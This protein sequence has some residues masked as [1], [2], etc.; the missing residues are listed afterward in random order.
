MGNIDK[1]AVA[2]NEYSGGASGKQDLKGIGT[3]N[4]TREVIKKIVA[5]GDA[6]VEAILKSV[7]TKTIFE[8]VNNLKE[9]YS[10]DG[11][12]PL[13]DDNGVN[14]KSSGDVSN[15]VVK[16]DSSD[17]V[18]QDGSKSF[19]LNKSSH[20]IPRS[21]RASRLRAEGKDGVKSPQGTPPSSRSSSQSNKKTPS[22]V[23][24]KSALTAATKRTP[25]PASSDNIRRAT[26]S[27]NSVARKDKTATETS[28]K[29][30]KS[31]ASSKELASSPFARRQARLKA[32]AAAAEASKTNEKG[33]F[34][35]KSINAAKSS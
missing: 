5:N 11:Q 33:N 30:T 32:E 22:S 3:D 14:K 23:A 10:I 19:K 6:E 7:D 34:A 12:L 4:S 35:D 20:H 27:A 1:A 25:S 28:T 24:S 26:T 15:D 18:V 16:K 21:T 2:I 17:I 13:S 29:K 31:T 9:K 8:M